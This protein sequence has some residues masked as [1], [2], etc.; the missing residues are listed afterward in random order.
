MNLSGLSGQEKAKVEA[1][2]SVVTS[3]RSPISENNVEMMYKN[4]YMKRMIQES[5]QSA[6]SVSMPDLSKTE[7]LRQEN[8][9]ERSVDEIYGVHEVDESV[10]VEENSRENLRS[11]TDSENITETETDVLKTREFLNETVETS[12][13]IREALPANDREIPRADTSQRRVKFEEGSEVEEIKI[14]RTQVLAYIENNYED[15]SRSFS[16]NKLNENISNFDESSTDYHGSF[17]NIESNFK[18][19]EDY[20]F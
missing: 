13:E 18:E 4:Q 16:Q 20:K 2:Q 15:K 8:Y 5:L 14:E 10:I 3:S 12:P 11:D 1:V 6:N 19:S 17:I 7:S 9:H